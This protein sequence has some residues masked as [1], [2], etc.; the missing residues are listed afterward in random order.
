MI[1]IAYSF[2]FVPYLLLSIFIVR[3]TMQWARNHERR[4]RL[5]G[6]I[7]GFVMY[8]L[9]FWD[10]LPTLIVHKYYCATECRFEV[11][12]TAEQWRQENPD[13]VVGP[14]KMPE[15]M[16]LDSQGYGTLY[17][18][19]GTK[20]RYYSG[21][22]VSEPSLDFNNMNGDMGHWLNDRFYQ[23]TG[24]GKSFLATRVSKTLLIDS[25]SGEVVSE[26]VDVSSGYHEG[27]W[28]VMKIWL[29]MKICS[30]SENEKHLA[31]ETFK[32]FKNLWA[33]YE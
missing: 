7:A 8:N 11:Y 3:R 10:F 32:R 1:L 26:Y 17:E 27:D 20:L 23:K 21:N 28:K 12:K 14:I 2:F 15:G 18:S 33:K 16:A 9:V 25:F 6:F 24:V 13:A 31:I 29:D 4:P 30:P 22:G 5:W 19:D